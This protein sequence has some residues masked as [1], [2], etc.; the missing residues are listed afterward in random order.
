M[1]FRRRIERESK[2]FFFFVHKVDSFSSSSRFVF[3]III[4]S[5]VCL[6]RRFSKRS[7]QEENEA[8][9]KKL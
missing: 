8:S 4:G 3:I 5:R 6:I 7:N 2:V 1:A 9:L